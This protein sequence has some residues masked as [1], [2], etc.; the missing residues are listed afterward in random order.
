MGAASSEPLTPSDGAA[1]APSSAGAIMRR[2]EQRTAVLTNLDDDRQYVLL[3]NADQ[4]TQLEI[5]CVGGSVD[6][7]MALAIGGSAYPLRPTLLE[8]TPRRAL[9][10]VPWSR[11]TAY[12]TPLREPVV[13]RATERLFDQL[14]AQPSKESLQLCRHARLIVGSDRPERTLGGAEVRAVAALAVDLDLTVIY[15]G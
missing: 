7:A 11:L 14:F 15:Y 13:N 6:D 1:G 12:C 3:L 8:L 9:A 2:S 4:P 10:D 5:C